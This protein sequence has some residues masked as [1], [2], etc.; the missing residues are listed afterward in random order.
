MS[1]QTNI[2]D[3]KIFIKNIREYI[4]PK[5]PTRDDQTSILIAAIKIQEE[6]GELSN[7]ILK[8]F[9]HQRDEKLDQNSLKHL[10][11][12]MADVVL[13]TFMLAQEMNIDIEEALNEKM[14]IIQQRFQ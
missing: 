7:E 12:E 13:S 1:N 4:T 11:L 2:N 8:H 10:Q 9:K 14:S 3:L 5:M 6:L